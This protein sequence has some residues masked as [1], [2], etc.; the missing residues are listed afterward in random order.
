MQVAETG[1]CIGDEIE[2][3]LRVLLVHLVEKLLDQTLYLRVLVLEEQGHVTHVAL[4]LDHVVQGEMGNDRQ[5]GLTHLSILL[6]QVLIEVFVVGL[7]DVG[8]AVQQVSHSDNDVVLDDG[9]GVGTVEESHH[10]W[11]LL[12]AEVR[13][14]AHE[15]AVGEH[16]DDL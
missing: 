1:Q 8:E 6:V 9:V 10:V 13:T 4:D 2:E 15:L 16:T 12:F 7:D 5:S 3:H 11:E 14:E